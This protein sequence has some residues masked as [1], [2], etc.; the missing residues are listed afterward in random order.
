MKINNSSSNLAFGRSKYISEAAQ[1]AIIARNDLLYK[2][3]P[4]SNASKSKKVGMTL[5]EI[6]QEQLEIALKNGFG[7][8]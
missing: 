2:Q 5:A 4:S 6:A 7:R 8:R 1:K 3:I